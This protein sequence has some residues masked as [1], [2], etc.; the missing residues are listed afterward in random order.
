MTHRYKTKG[1][2]SVYID[3]EMDGNIVKDIEFHGGCDGNLK[4]ICSLAAGHSYDDLKDKLEGI[5]CG[6]KKTSCP[7][8]LVK[9]IEF[10]MTNP[11][12]M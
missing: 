10:A 8:Q 7:D 11:P 12:N 9:A 1:T 6:F 5:H 2:C 4:G 3:L